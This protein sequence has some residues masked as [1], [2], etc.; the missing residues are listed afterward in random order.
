MLE[1]QNEHCAKSSQKSVP[2]GANENDEAP[3]GLSPGSSQFSGDKGEENN[4]G[5]KVD[6]ELIDQIWD[7]YDEDASGELDK[8]ETRKF[9]TDMMGNMDGSGDFTEEAFEELFT[10]FDKDGDGTIAKP[11]MSAFI[12][13]LLGGPPS[14]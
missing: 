5:F 1:E 9:V 7:Q 10:E 14:E 3:I 11:E 2:E 6:D 8:E 4:A 12:N 13:Q